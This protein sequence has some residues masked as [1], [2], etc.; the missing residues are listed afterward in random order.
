MAVIPT[1]RVAATNYRVLEYFGS[2]AFLEVHLE[3][4]RTH[5]IRVHFSYLG[6]P[7]VGDPV[8]GRKKELVP[9]T[10]QALHAATLGFIHPRT[11]KYLEFTTELPE[12]VEKALAWCRKTK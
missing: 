9:I 5:Q 4:G 6:Y 1:G 2:Y 3:T 12:V 8:Y 7:V 10:G 11:R